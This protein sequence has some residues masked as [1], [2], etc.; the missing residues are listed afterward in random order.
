MKKN[1]QLFLLAGLVAS[2]GFTSCSEEDT[3]VTP[4]TTTYGTISS[5]SAK[6]LG[7][8]T[9]ANVGSFFATDSGVVYRSAVVGASTLLQ[10]RIDLVY[11]YG[12]SNQA[13]IGAPND[14]VVAFAHLN[15]S[16]LSLWTTKNATKFYATSITPEAFIASSNDSLVKTIDAASISSSLVNLLTVGKVVAFKTAAGKYGL[17]HVQSIDGTTGTD[18]SITINV[19]VQK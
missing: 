1:I 14:S 10:G 13:T 4:T 5:Y 15:N 9:N 11:F 12:N 16:S 18:R 19:K 7:G 6:L 3:T 17:Y 8:Q 2:V